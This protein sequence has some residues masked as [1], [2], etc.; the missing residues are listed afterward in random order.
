MKKVA[1]FIC[2]I[3]KIILVFSTCF[4]FMTCDSWMNDNNFFSDIED[5]VKVANASEVSVYFRYA[6]TV[7][8]TVTPTMVTTE[9]VDVPFSV[10]AITNDSYGF[11]RWAAFSTNDFPTGSQYAKLVY[12]S[13][14]VTNYQP[15]ELDES[16]VKFDDRTS[17]TT[18]VSILA[19][20]SDIWIMPVCANRPTV[21]L[22]LPTASTTSVVRN[23]AIRIIFSKAM[24]SSYFFTTNSDGS[25][26]LT[27][28]IVIQEITGA[29][30]DNPTTTTI[31]GK[32]TKAS[33][34]STKKILILKLGSG[35]AMSANTSMKVS[36]SKAVCDSDGYAMASDYIL[37]FTTGTKSDTYAPIIKTLTGGYTDCTSFSCSSNTEAETIAANTSL[38]NASF[39]SDMMLQRTSGKVN[40]Y[41]YAADI[42]ESDTTGNA[43]ETDVTQL[44]MRVTRLFDLNGNAISS[45]SA[46]TVSAM[47]YVQYSSGD[48]ASDLTGDFST[49]TNQVNATDPTK[50]TKVG[51]LFT[52]DV[53]SIADGLLKIDVWATDSVGNAGID[54]SAAT[55]TQNGNGY[56]SIFVVKDTAAPDIASQIA[57]IKNGSKLTWFN[58]ST[59]KELELSGGS[60][61]KDDACDK[62]QPTKLY[63]AFKAGTDTSWSISTTDSAWKLTSAGDYALSNAT[64]SQ[65]GSVNIL[66]VLKDDLGNISP[67]AS[68]SSIKY[69][70]TAPATNPSV[71][72]TQPSA[73]TNSWSTSGSLPVTITC[74]DY[75]CTNAESTTA[76]S[77]MKGFLIN[78]SEYTSGDET[79]TA[80]LEYK[81]L[82][83]QSD[84][85]SVTDFHAGAWNSTSNTYSLSTNL[86]STND[87][88][89]TY[90]IYAVDNAY[91]VSS[92]TKVDV[93]NDTVAPDLTSVSVLNAITS[94]S[95]NGT[96]N[97]ITTTSGGAK[98]WVK[99]STVNTNALVT[100]SLKYTETG[101]GVYRI[102]VSG[103]A[104]L[105]GASTVTDSS[106]AV[107]A[108][109]LGASDKYIQI[110]SAETTGTDA[111][112][113]VT[114]VT[115][116]NYNTSSANTPNV[117]I[118]DFATNASSTYSSYSVYADCKRPSV[119]T[120]ARY[121][122]TYSLASTNSYAEPGYTAVTLNTLTVP[123]VVD[124]YDSG[125]KTV[126][127]T[128]R[129]RFTNNSVVTLYHAASSSW[130]TGVTLAGTVSKTSYEGDTI[131]F[132]TPI[133]SNTTTNPD[134]M[135]TV[136]N[137]QLLASD[138]AAAVSTS[139]SGISVGVKLT[140]AAGWTD[141]TSTTGASAA[142]RAY[143]ITYDWEAPKSSDSGLFVT[144]SDKYVSSSASVNVYPH[145]SETNTYGVVLDSTNKNGDGTTIRYFYTSAMYSNAYGAILGIPA[146]DNIALRG[147]GSTGSY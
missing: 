122:Q 117:Y 138:N 82:Q 92:Y 131:T 118:T 134:F 25:T 45:P 33:L 40:I 13:D 57:N 14:Y 2:T 99:G 10:T 71:T 78:T 64:S 130:G 146:T 66:A 80:S 16:V 51:Y 9:K 46:V 4:L 90:F 55:Y 63:W 35:Q 38:S 135:I 3:T 144:T 93:I 103:G 44:N 68:L 107:I 133:T 76:A 121:S 52:Y 69:D 86:A 83:L 6:S 84:P 106:G 74:N 18:S 105:T 31:S 137:V 29:A 59:L 79:D 53:S 32:F 123:F 39:T 47:P 70:N 142:S 62:M 36:I 42:S 110:A 104:S 108:S 114:N 23:Q 111:T 129:A 96:I 56:K 27:D 28:N 54:M 67:A 11:Y 5:E 87:S 20:R 147:C 50:T 125:V 124:G 115:L 34:S 97:S 8:G 15:K 116:T 89:V 61:I 17:A 1:K 37:T 60:T 22:T 128:S 12:D 26:T 21:S 30:T 112:L 81:L 19:E 43:G 91:N 119:Y 141:G 85:T 101:S 139:E 88:T 100:L 94:T 58:A 102:Y 24:D 41:A 126:Q 77:G 75:G 136:T 98:N 49:I 127:L 95:Y 73:G 140:S 132:E 48:N 109:S 7:M 65:D 113:L 143:S 145:A 72:S 120:T